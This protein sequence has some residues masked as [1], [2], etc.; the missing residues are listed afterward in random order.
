MYL[1]TILIFLNFFTT[2]FPKDLL[3]FSQSI[4]CSPRNRI[5]TNS[6]VFISTQAPP[7][8]AG[9]DQHGITGLTACSSPVSAS[10]LAG[11]SSQQRPGRNVSHQRWGI[12]NKRHLFPKTE[13]Q[14]EILSVSNGFTSRAHPT[15]RC[16]RREW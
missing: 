2:G 14:A 16:L 9:Q 1:K 4:I 5:G 13:G 10:H 8:V 15:R 12:H 11:S 7:Q 3:V 6:P